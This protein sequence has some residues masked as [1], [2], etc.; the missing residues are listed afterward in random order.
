LN[1]GL[2]LLKLLP[3]TPERAQQELALHIALGV[4]LLMTKGY[5]APEVEHAYARARELCQQ[6]GESPQLLPALAGLFQFYFV[7]ADLHAARE[8]GKQLLTLAQR[9]HDPVLLARGH[10]SLGLPLFGL[11]EFAL[12]REHLE[13]GAALYDPRRHGSPVFRAVQDRMVILS[14]AAAALWQLGYPDQALERSHE[15]L[16]LARELSHPFSLA[17]ALDLA[18][19]LHQFRREWQAVQEQAE[20]AM[21]LSA[22]HGFSYWLAV[23]T[24]LR[25]WARAEQG[26]GEEGL[27]HI[28]QGLAACRPTRAELAWPHWLALLADVYG[29]RG[30]TQEGLATVAEALARV[31]KTGERWYEAELHR[32]KGELSLQSGVRGPESQIPTPQHLTP[33]TQ[34]EA[35]ECFH[36]AIEIARRQQAKSLELRAALSLA[37]LWQRRGKKKQARSILAD[38][39]GW[40]TEG[41]G[42]VDLTEAKALLKALS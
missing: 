16:A 28:H 21:T 3:D 31:E 13:Q 34:S 1:K 41:F 18:S 32:L 38:V 12:A 4:P 8:L 19:W 25:G 5:A 36:K 42:T 7:R 37:R 11:G 24:I 26:Y 14:Y 22:D 39:Y 6:L 2:A 17:V 20:A 10:M 15:A 35:E 29:K 40:F 33:S 30:Q 9:R 23:G 27:V